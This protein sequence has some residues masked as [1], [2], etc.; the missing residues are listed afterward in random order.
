MDLLAIAAADP[1]VIPLW[2]AFLFAIGMYPVGMFFGCNTCC[3]PCGCTEGSLPPAVT[4]SID[5]FT[6]GQ[7]PGYWLC[8]LVFSSD[9]GADAA[10]VVSAPGGKA[11]EDAG[12]ASATLV[13]DGGSG[14]ARI[15]RVAPTVTA[16]PDGDGSG[17]EITVNLE[18]ITHEGRP[19]WQIGSLSVADGGSGYPESGSITITTATGDTTA[20]DPQ[21]GFPAKAVAS[22]AC[23]RV[24]PT[25]SLSVNGTGSGASL[26]PTLSSY[27]DLTFGTFW[28]VSSV[29]VDDGGSGYT[30]GDPVQF[31]IDDGTNGGVGL[32]FSMSVEV[33]QDG[34][35]TAVVVD[36]PTFGNP[37]L[38]RGFAYKNSGIIASASV[39]ESNRGIYYRDDPTLPGEKATVTVTA[40]QQ[41]PTS[42]TAAGA[43]F[44]VVIDDDASS[45]TFGQITAVNID[46]GGDDYLAYEW[47]EAYL[48]GV[49][50]VL[51]RTEEGDGTSNSC[52]YYKGDCGRSFLVRYRGPSLPPLVVLDSGCNSFSL[53]ATENVTNCSEMSFTAEDE[54]GRSVTVSA[55]GEPEEKNCNDCVGSV[56]VNGVEVPVNTGEYVLVSVDPEPTIAQRFVIQGQAAGLIDNWW[57]T[58]GWARAYAFCDGNEIFVE[59]YG[60]V[61]GL[62]NIFNQF[63]PSYA[64]EEDLAVYDQLTVGAKRSSDPHFAAYNI[65][66]IGESSI[67]GNGLLERRSFGV[68]RGDD[69]VGPEWRLVLSHDPANFEP[70]IHSSSVL[71][72]SFA[73]LQAASRQI[74]GDGIECGPV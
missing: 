66:I 8:P 42:E 52:H 16:T 39:D 26:T 45:P 51:P 2:A 32:P 28:Y 49:S 34:A 17:A 58:Y 9:F 13:T 68:V 3:D 64:T 23:Q 59:V 14:Y 6:D 21:Y 4:L 1:T 5:G 47:C 7:T 35:V 48:Q 44:S 62:V 12:P 40:N 37:Y 71:P 65:A 11:D 74:T 25:V 56:L 43:A 19:A 36:E 30:A 31:T 63:P 22:Y 67:A 69:C 57:R 38:N 60:G 53:E 20:L 33:D 50:V 72:P 29:T 55:G 10:G 46:D 15:A 70:S 54:D 41:G 27:E 18:Q 61:L 24:E 73:I